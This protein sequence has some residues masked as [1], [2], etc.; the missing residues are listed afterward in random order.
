MLK[1]QAVKFYK[2]GLRTLEFENAKIKKEKREGTE[3]SFRIR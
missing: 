3:K 2:I 1:L